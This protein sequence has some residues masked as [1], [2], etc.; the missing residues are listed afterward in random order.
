VFTKHR[1]SLIALA[2][3]ALLAVAHTWPLAA[4]PDTYSR[5]DNMDTQLNEWTMAWVAHQV[6]RDPV[7]LFDAPIFYPEKHTLAFSEHLFVQGVMAMPLYWAGA[8]P[9]A[10]FNIMIIVGLALTGWTT[11]LVMRRWTGSWLAAILAGSLMAFNAST[12]SRLVHIQA[13]HLQFFPLML[14]ALDQLLRE[15]RFRWALR[16]GWWFALEA[17]TSVY[18]L[19]FITFVAAASILVRPRE[20]S[21]RCK[22][23]AVTGLAGVALAAVILTPFMIPYYR[24]H[25]EQEQFTRTIQDV[26]RYSAHWK[27]YLASAGTLHTELLGW[28]RGYA[29]ADYLFPGV[30]ALLFTLVA[31]V[32]LRAFTDLRARMALGFGLLCFALSFGPQFPLYAP[33]YKAIPLLEAIRG[34]ARFGQMV[35]AA[36]ALLAGFGLAWLMTKLPRAAAVALGLVAVIGA[37]AEAWRAPIGYCG[38]APAP[39]PAFTG[40]PPIFKTLDRPD[41]KAIVVLPYYPP[42]MSVMYNARYMLQATAH[43]KPMLNGYSGY[44]PTSVFLHNRGVYDF[45]SPHAIDYLK[46]L[47]VTHALVDSRNVGPDVVEAIKASDAL[48]LEETDGNLLI[49]RIK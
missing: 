1:S 49:L 21:R 18:F 27:N 11:A 37:N 2:L 46:G 36:V 39:C 9:V 48:T 42:G 25:Q 12:L 47:G 44:M 24:A 35:L 28:S 26:A 20:W 31:L 10:A 33:L 23:F 22:A 29:D 38:T 15:P 16:F 34:A 30:T 41:V 13:L 8:S 19:V 5:N 6:V 17:L 43:F 32:S 7:H 40:I 3:F 14:F 45:P 4:G